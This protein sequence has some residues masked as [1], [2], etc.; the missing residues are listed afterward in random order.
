MEL[1]YLISLLLWI[2]LAVAVL[3]HL[4][5]NRVAFV[6]VRTISAVSLILLE[7]PQILWIS[8]TLRW[9]AVVLKKVRWFD[10][11]PLH[12][13]WSFP[14]RISSVNGNNSAGNC[15]FG[16][17][18]WRLHDGKL[19]FCAVCFLSVATFKILLYK[20]SPKRNS[21][22]DVKGHFSSIRGTE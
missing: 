10:E 12:K 4:V 18:Y 1:P 22:C 19:H 13:K 9:I 2:F 20:S 7:L 17:I 21:T 16:H 14:L 5:L 3:W 15:R 6:L 11:V 8:E